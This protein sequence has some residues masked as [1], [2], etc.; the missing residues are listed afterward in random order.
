MDTEAHA[1]DTIPANIAIIGMACR[2]PGADDVDQFWRNVRE[3]VESIRTF[4]DEQLR[5]AGVPPE[6]ISDPRYVKCSAPIN[7]VA[8]FDAGYFGFLK[9]DVETMDPQ[10]RIFLECAVWALEDAGYDPDRYDGL[11]GVYAGSTMNTYLLMNL[12]GNDMVDIVGDHAVMIGNDKDYLPDAGRLQVRAAR[13]GLRRPNGV[14]DVTDR[15]A[16]RVPGD[17]GWGMR[18]CPGRWRLGADAARRRLPAKRHRL[19]RRKV[20][21]LRRGRP[22][23]CGRQRGWRGGAQTP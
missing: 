20:P 6:L 1:S 23:Q 18:H 8:G 3:G 17:P 5:A 15:G 2:F 14:L 12:I 7:D 10:H 9:R 22:R 19:T 11:I 16:R 13:T 21:G 4:D